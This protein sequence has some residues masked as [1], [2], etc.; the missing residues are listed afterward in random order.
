MLE[1]GSSVESGAVCAVKAVVR[2]AREKG[3]LFL[4]DVFYYLVGNPLF[5]F[6][7]WLRRDEVHDFSIGFNCADPEHRAEFIETLKSCYFMS[8]AEFPGDNHF[9]LFSAHPGFKLGMEIDFGCGVF[10][11]VGEKLKGK[12]GRFVWAVYM[13]RTATRR[14]LYQHGELTI[15]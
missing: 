5:E 10:G 3:R 12:N 6:F 7:H 9:L 14:A 15:N 11:V 13:D 2:R 8:I 4:S 1:S